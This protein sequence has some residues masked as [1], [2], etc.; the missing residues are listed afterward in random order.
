MPLLSVVSR[1]VEGISCSTLMF[2]S[3][4]KSMY[5]N[6]ACEIHSFALTY[7][8]FHQMTIGGEG[9]IQQ[10][11]HTKTKTSAPADKVRSRSRVQIPFWPL[12]D[13][14]LGSP[15]FNLSATLVNSELVCL[16]PVGILNLVKF[17]YHCLFALV[18]KKPQWGVANYVCIYTFTFI[19]RILKRA[20]VCKGQGAHL[21]L[22][23][24]LNVIQYIL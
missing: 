2:S 15:E 14:V 4:S 16:P 11:S 13:V 18:L 6:G 19:G 5:S 24:R 12:T 20:L 21:R 10:L 3:N 23:E 7:N 1:V 9:G 8:L 22:F 17:I